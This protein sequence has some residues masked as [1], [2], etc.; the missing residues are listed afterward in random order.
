[1]LCTRQRVLRLGFAQP[2]L[3][4]SDRL[5]PLVFELGDFARVAFFVLANLL[6][7]AFAGTSLLTFVLSFGGGV[8]HAGTFTLANPF[9]ARVNGATVLFEL[10]EGAVEFIFG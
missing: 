6:V 5:V 10:G 2:Q 9:E 3:R 1:M 4:L 8:A 7:G